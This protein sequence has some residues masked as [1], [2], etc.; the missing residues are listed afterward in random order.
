MVGSVYLESGTTA[1]L[2]KLGLR[3]ELVRRIKLA[4]VA[5]LLNYFAKF[6]EFVKV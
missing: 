5:D 6:G 3:V 1:A 4:S 2:L